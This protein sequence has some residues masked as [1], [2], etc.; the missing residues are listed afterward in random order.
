MKDNLGNRMKENY[1]NRAKTRLLR[2]TLVIIRLNSKAFH[3]FTKSFDKSFDKILT[4]VMQQ[5]ILSLCK[6]VQGW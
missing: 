1:E 5:T 3:I 2:R 6:E 4:K